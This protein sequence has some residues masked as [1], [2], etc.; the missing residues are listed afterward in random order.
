M[1]EEMNAMKS[2][3]NSTWVFVKRTHDMNG[4][5][6]KLIYKL[7]CNMAGSMDRYRARLVAR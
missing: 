1:N 3:C 6:S 5:G 7:K 2:Y 4:I